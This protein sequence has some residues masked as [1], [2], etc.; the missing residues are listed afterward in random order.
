MPPDALLD[1][2]KNPYQ[3]DA[4]GPKNGGKQPDIWTVTPEGK[5]IGNWWIRR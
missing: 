3:Y 4:A 1:H 5:V 2:W